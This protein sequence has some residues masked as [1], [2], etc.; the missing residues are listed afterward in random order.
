MGGPL[1]SRSIH[2]RSE[3]EGIQTRKDDGTRRRADKIEREVDR[4]T[5][6]DPSYARKEEQDIDM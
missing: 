2:A 3:R 1:D 6:R 5:D 4:Q